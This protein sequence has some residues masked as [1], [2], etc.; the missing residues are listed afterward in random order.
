MRPMMNHSRSHEQLSSSAEIGKR[1]AELHRLL[2]YPI[3]DRKTGRNFE[4]IEAVSEDPHFQ[5]Q[6]KLI[7]ELVDKLFDQVCTTL[8]PKQEVLD[9]S[10][11]GKLGHLANAPRPSLSRPLLGSRPLP[12]PIHLRRSSV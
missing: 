9:R 6:G 12:S 11:L 2:A 5:N 8:H 10:T 1:G 4:E 3:F 7:D